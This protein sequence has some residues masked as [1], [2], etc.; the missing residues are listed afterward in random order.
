M[1]VV[2]GRILLNELWA[3]ATRRRLVAATKMISEAM[4]YERPKQWPKA[5]IL[6]LYRL[7]KKVRIEVVYG[8][9]DNTQLYFTLDDANNLIAA[10]NAVLPVLEPAQ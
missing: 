6:D 2:D 5:A 9:T 8:Q 10:L 7:K 3:R 4:G 1:Q